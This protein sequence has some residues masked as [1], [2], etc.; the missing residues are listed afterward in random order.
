MT[1]SQP[2]VEL[3]TLIRVPREKVFAAWTD[4]KILAR[5][6]APGNS[7]V[8]ES[9]IDLRVGGAYRIRMKGEMGGRPYDVRIRGIYE[10]IVPHEL[11]S[12]TWAYEDDERQRT[13]GESQV[14]VVLK[15]VPQGTELT[16]IHSKIATQEKREGHRRGWTDS[17]GKLETLL[18]G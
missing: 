11:L 4:P 6:M 14:T 3:R 1:P 15:S 10:K 16:L 8:L 12:F 9:V 18:L 13:V 5:W 17:L 2:H 7:E